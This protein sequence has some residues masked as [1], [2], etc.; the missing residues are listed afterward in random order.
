[1]PRTTV[2][3]QILAYFVTEFI[4]GA[5]EKEEM[6]IGI[7]VMSAIDVPPWEVYTYRASN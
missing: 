6:V 5:F 7:L 4:E 2:K 1:M 3:G